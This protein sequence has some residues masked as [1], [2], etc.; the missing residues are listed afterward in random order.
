MAPRPLDIHL[1]HF[2]D[3]CGDNTYERLLQAN[4]LDL[5]LLERVIEE[6]HRRLQLIPSHEERLKHYLRSRS[7]LDPVA[8]RAVLASNH[9]NDFVRYANLGAN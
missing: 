7:I 8:V 4:S 6:V 2:R 9:P 5:A 3:A 1:A